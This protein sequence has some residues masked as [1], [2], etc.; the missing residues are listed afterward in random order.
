MKLYIVIY[1]IIIHTTI[2]GL[3]NVKKITISTNTYNMNARII[4]C[5]KE[6]IIINKL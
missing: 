4:V 2:I 6:F 1:C 5:D 3:K